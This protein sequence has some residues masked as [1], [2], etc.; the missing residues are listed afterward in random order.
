MSKRTQF[1]LLIVILCIPAAIFTFLKLFGD[2]RFDVEVFHRNGVSKAGCSHFTGQYTVPDS[3]IGSDRQ[4]RN[5]IIMIDRG[6]DRKRVSNVAA[7]LEDVF[8]ETIAWRV[9]IT[10][11]LRSPTKNQRPFQD[12]AA[13]VRCGLLMDDGSQVALIDHRGRI[14][15]YYTLEPDEIDRLIVETKILLEND[16]REEK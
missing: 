1:I 8:K 6:T 11:G 3:L 12:L 10:N 13:V 4:R 15:G 14:R 16:G 5:N 2:N 7:R 9:F